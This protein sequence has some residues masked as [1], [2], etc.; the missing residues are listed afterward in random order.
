[1]DGKDAKGDPPQ[2]IRKNTHSKPNAKEAMEAAKLDEKP[3]KSRSIP[4]VSELGSEVE[5]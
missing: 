5:E 2:E 1:M 3:V 4:A